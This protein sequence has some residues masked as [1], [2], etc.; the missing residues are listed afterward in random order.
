MQKKRNRGAT[1][2]EVVLGV[3]LI[4]M[5]FGGLFLFYRSVVD[6]LSNTDL[7]TMGTAILNKEMET[8]RNLPFDQVGTQ[9]G[10]PSGVLQQIKI[11]T[12]TTDRVFA[13]K[14][15]VRNIDDPF[16]GILGGNPNDTAPAD[17]KLVELEAT[18]TTCPN[19]IPLILT[20]RIA[21]KNLE[22]S[23]NS[24]SLFVNVINAGGAPVP[25][26]SVHV[27]NTSTT[28][29][30]DLTDTTNQNGV[31][32]LVGVP[33]STQG[34]Q[35][36]VTKVG[37]STDQTYPVG[38][39]ANP[40]PIVGHLSVLAQTLTPVTFQID[41]LAPFVMETK[42][43][44][45]AGVGSQPFVITGS[46]LIGTDPDIIKFSTSSQTGVDGTKVYAGIE[47]GSH[48][49]S[50]SGGYDLLGT[51]P[52]TPAYIAPA[53][54]A[55]FAFI[56]RA[57]DPNSLLITVKEGVSGA[58]I[59]GATVELT[60][61]GFS[62]AKK[63]GEFYRSQTDW[64]AGTYSEQSGVD[65]VG[66]PGIITMAYGAGGYSTT[67][68]AYLISETLDFGATSTTYGNV[69]WNPASQPGSTG[70]DSLRLQFAANSDD[71]TWNFIGPDGTAGTFYT[72]SSVALHASLTNNRYFRYKVL[73]STEDAGTTPELRDLTVYFSGPCVPL[74]QVLFQNLSAGTYFAEATVPGYLP[75]TSSISVSGEWTQ[76]EINLS[77]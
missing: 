22:S 32:Q 67:S 57:A 4:F 71:T 64:S 73:L 37:Y 28:P 26:A 2:I 76:A 13:I 35:V 12:T 62:G 44:F 42:D 74:G 16:D 77:P 38:V 24:G 30:I 17:Y 41:L 15:T 59:P 56:L 5:L 50:Y 8:V 10:I 69:L 66:T 54:N 7:R 34:Y 72:S 75:A 3:G 43:A 39:P 27:V 45:C 29:A 19:F 40:N 47:W 1:L 31:L 68:V 11:A 25:G 58:P 18:C 61:T 48:A 21:P 65:P 55:V 51:L 33:T 6:V 70:A 52:L 20:A 53:T 49:F 9:G 36:T 60:K 63:T 23:A 46:K 14:T